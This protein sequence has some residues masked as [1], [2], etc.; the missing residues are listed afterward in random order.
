MGKIAL[1]V[2]QTS[3]CSCVDREEDDDWRGRQELVTGD[4]WIKNKT[5]EM[6]RLL[7]PQLCR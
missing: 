4:V 7:E 1:E 5:G 3:R 6:V 2:T